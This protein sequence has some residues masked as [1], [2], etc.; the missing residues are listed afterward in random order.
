MICWS[1]TP[2]RAAP[3]HYLPEEYQG[4]SGSPVSY[5]EVCYRPQV[6]VCLC[7]CSLS[8]MPLTTEACHPAQP[9][10]TVNGC[11]SA[12][13]VITAVLAVAIERKVPT[14]A[15]GAGRL[16]LTSGVML[17]VYEGAGGTPRGIMICIAGA[18][19]AL[20]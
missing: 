17:A 13:P 6:Q 18:G 15:E 14:Q 16:V 8:A 10:S 7:G 1:A 4:E 9:D 19:C 20:V 5:Q 11:R 2:A 3:A 12:I